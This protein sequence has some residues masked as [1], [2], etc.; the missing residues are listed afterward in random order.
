MSKKV[1]IFNLLYG[2]LEAVYLNHCYE[3]PFDFLYGPESGF[4][5]L[6][7][8]RWIMLFLPVWMLSLWQYEEAFQEMKLTVYRYRNIM[9]WWR[10]V[11]FRIVLY[12]LNAYLVLFILLV[13]GEE[14][15][16]SVNSLQIMGTVAVHASGLFAIGSWIQLL[17]GS[18]IVSGIL[19]VF[20]EF[21][22]LN[23]ISGF[24]IYPKYIFSAWGVRCYAASLYGEGGYPMLF[25]SGIQI[26]LLAGIF[27]PY[28]GFVKMILVRRLS[29]EKND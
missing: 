17:S 2:G 1:Y 18:R 3:S 24:G 9:K 19:L 21:V 26:L 25:I 15:R 10:A 16:V 29:N 22:G 27:M 23:C 11:N 20:M 4:T 13:L 5:F 7:M 28:A 8:V 12:V 6:E 14:G